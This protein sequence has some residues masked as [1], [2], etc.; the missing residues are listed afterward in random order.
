MLLAALSVLAVLSGCAQRLPGEALILAESGAR[1]RALET[2]LLARVAED[3]E[4]ATALRRL[5]LVQLRLDKPG[6]AERHALRAVDASPF[7]P[8][9]LE[10]L[11]RIQL[12]NGKLLPALTAF[13]QALALEPE[14]MA[15][16]LGHA[17]AQ[18]A[19][20]APAK[21]LKALRQATRRSPR[22]FAA[23]YLQ[24]RLLLA[25]GR[26]AQAETAI[27]QARR[28]RPGHSGALLLHA[29]I[30]RAGGKTG[31]ALLLIR[32][33]L[34]NPPK[35]AELP[36]AMLLSA[37]LKAQLRLHVERKDWEAAGGTL[38]R[39]KASRPLDAAE[40]LLKVRILEGQGRGGQARAELEALI[41][42]HPGFAPARVWKGKGLIAEGRPAE[43]LEAL[44]RAVALAPR[45]ARGHYWKA[46]AHFQGDEAPAGEAALALA[47]R[48][49]GDAR[50]AGNPARLKTSLRLLRIVRL[51]AAAR[52][53][54]AG[55]ALR[56]FQ[57]SHPDHPAGWL[58]RAAVASLRGTVASLRGTVASLRGKLKESRRLLERAHPAFRPADLRFARLRLAYLEGRHRQVLERS[59]KLLAHPRL[60]WRAAYLRA[61]ALW[62]LGREGA[63]LAVLAP[64]LKRRSGGPRF[65]Y[66]TGYLHL[67]R[68]ETLS[69]ERAFDAGLDPFPNH[70]L[71]LEGLSRM[72]MAEREW[73]KARGILER[74]LK[75][76][77][78]HRRMFLDRLAW[79][80]RE[81]V[82]RKNQAGKPDPG[83]QAL[84]RFLAGADS[85]LSI[86]AGGTM[87]QI[88]Y[89]SF[90][91]G[92]EE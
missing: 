38:S 30:L 54:A 66:L 91:P 29:E 46:V 41:A 36:K 4:N 11:G 75:T 32:T 5:A 40:R 31:P 34:K 72:A 65:H 33:A 88:L 87:R 53:D 43:A 71:L 82:A 80:A 47:E 56:K 3:P 12:R 79:V 52:A 19:L 62:R 9:A 37:L 58:M 50:Q 68:G 14:F 45:D 39:L 28:T 73:G 69:A 83:R 60:G 57:R 42:A 25:M 1:L 64:H 76:P 24:A 86:T 85:P 51:I 23:R 74:G 81:E 63:A 35:D 15:A 70:P 6:D 92:L 2:T 26:T 13:D 21:A 27:Q 20:E 8:M 77:G 61:E 89:G 49:A 90:I 55:E 67:L 10:M 7:D 44:G 18:Q 22:H 16:T 48:L 17:R 84:R 78:P 59:A